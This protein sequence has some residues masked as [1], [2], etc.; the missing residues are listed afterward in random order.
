[1]G[2]GSP[3]RDRVGNPLANIV[4][5]WCDARALP[6]I[7]V[8]KA[9]QPGQ[10]DV[11]EVDASPLRM[12]GPAPHAAFVEACNA[13]ARAV[14]CPRCGPH[15]DEALWPRDLWHAFWCLGRCWG[16]PARPPSPQSTPPPQLQPT[17]SL[18]GSEIAEEIFWSCAPGSAKNL[19][20]LI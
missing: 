16:V 5:Q 14:G 7:T 2:L 19:F 15:S 18:A 20:P 1:M 11:V 6:F 9:V 8:R 3:P 17:P 12:A 10:G 13:V 4:R